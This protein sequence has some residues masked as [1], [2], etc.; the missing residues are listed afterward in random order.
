MAVWGIGLLPMVFL[1]FLPVQ[2]LAT[3]MI[4]PPSVSLSISTAVGVPTHY[5]QAGRNLSAGVGVK[6]A[7]WPI[8]IERYKQADFYVGALMPDGRYASWILGADG[9]A[10]LVTGPTPLP[11]MAHVLLETEPS[12]P[13]FQCLFSGTEPIGFYLAFALLVVPGADSLD[14]RNWIAVSTVPFTFN[15]QPGWPQG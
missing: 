3:E 11:Y 6:K 13:Y 15:P 4:P 12:P 1:A 8:P 9:A 14:T 2:A 5:F 10:V 7:P